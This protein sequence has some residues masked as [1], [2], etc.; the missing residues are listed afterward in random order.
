MKFQ[1]VHLH[2]VDHAFDIVDVKIVFAIAVFL[3]DK[4]DT[5]AWTELARMMF[6]EEALAYHAL[7]TT[8]QRRWPAR[9]FR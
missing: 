4:H 3:A 8:Y 7:R 6:L 9:Q 2:Q 1:H 5:H